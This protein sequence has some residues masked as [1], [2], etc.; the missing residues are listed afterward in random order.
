[1]QELGY[2]AAA[3]QQHGMVADWARGGLRWTF[4]LAGA[5]QLYNSYKELEY[6]ED[7]AAIPPG[8]TALL[9]SLSILLKSTY[10]IYQGYPWYGTGGEAAPTY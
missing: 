10:H 2:G 1:M 5:Q 4:D 9:H 3:R 7:M 8:V 6:W